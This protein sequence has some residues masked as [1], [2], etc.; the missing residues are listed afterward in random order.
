VSLVERTLCLVRSGDVFLDLEGVEH[1]DVSMGQSG[2]C[3]YSESV[4]FCMT[5]ALADGEEALGSLGLSQAKLRTF[6]QQ[7]G[8][9]AM[10]RVP[11][12]RPGLHLYVIRT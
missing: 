12:E 5:T 4:L 3:S 2:V 11:L 1:L 8:F 6:C 10:H 9:G 7:A